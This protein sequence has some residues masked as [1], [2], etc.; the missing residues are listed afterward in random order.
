VLSFRKLYPSLSRLLPLA[1]LLFVGGQKVSAQKV[2][3]TGTI[4]GGLNGTGILAGSPYGLSRT[5]GGISDVGLFIALGIPTSNISNFY[6]AGSIK[7]TFGTPTGVGTST[8]VGS[9]ETVPISVKSNKSLNL[10]VPIAG[11]NTFVQ[12][13]YG[14]TIPAGTTSYVK[15]KEKPTRNSVLDVALLG[16]LGLA[17]TNI[18]VGEVY[19][20]ALEPENFPGSAIP[21]HLPSVDQNT[22][23]AL[24]TVSNPTKTDLVID[25]NG[26]WYAAVAPT[27]TGT[28]NSVRLTGEFPSDLN[29]L[30]AANWVEFNVY[31]AFTNAGTACSFR[32]AYTNEGKASGIT[33][34]LGVASSLLDLSEI[35]KNPTRA[36][37]D[38]YGTYSAMSSGI[39]T[40]GL[41]S[42]VSQTLYFD[43]KATVSDNLRLQ[44]GL[45]PAL[46]SLTL[47]QLEGIKIKFYNGGSTS[48]ALTKSLGDL[49]TL[50]SLNLL[51]LASINGTSH[52]KLDLTFNPGVVFD[53]IE[54]SF[55]QGLL[56]V[57]LLGDALRIYDVSMAA[58]MPNITVQ[59]STVNSTNICE[60]NTA[61]FDV[62]ATASAGG[63]ISGYQWQYF[64][65]GNWIDAPSGTSNTLNITSATTAMNNRLYRVKVTGGNPSC[66]QD[67]FSNEVVLTVN[68]KPSITLGTVLDICIETLAASIP[69]TAIT[70]NP[71][72]YS[73]TWTDPS[74]TLANVVDATFPATSPLSIP[75][76]VSASTDTHHGTITVKNANGCTSSPAPFTLKI[77]PKLP[78][79][80]LTIT[81]N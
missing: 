56:G 59:P 74:S 13:R 18:V 28:Y 16:V 14:T 75:I 21:F 7:S 50:L 11:A 81:T 30:S 76:P 22:G 54:I 63:T 51:N 72:S 78:T 52:R 42:T 73:I 70:E 36:I 6:Y 37:D 67:V 53:R 23:T 5:S 48:P 17:S 35:V 26:E 10:L 20:N 58:S 40:V 43:H 15:L 33:L 57:G 77:N 27:A 8:I 12:F 39:L 79:P 2:Y 34:N 64:D 46:L 32:P 71:T 66:P 65:A 25:K 4:T 49:K 62:T 60:N 38:D 1:L 61:S 19:T 31:N 44:L 24:G 3:A 68:P 29:V 69:Y 47:A 45:N 41:L 9:S 55:E 80:N